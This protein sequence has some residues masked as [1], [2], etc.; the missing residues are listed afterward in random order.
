M[1]L[2]NGLAGSKTLNIRKT[3][4]SRTPL[5]GPRP[6]GAQTCRNPSLRST[7]PVRGPTPFARYVSPLS[8]NSSVADQDDKSQ[9]SLLYPNILDVSAT[10]PSPRLSA[11]N[12]SSARS[13]CVLCPHV[14][15]TTENRALE[16]GP[17]N[18]WVAVEVSGRL[19]QI[20]EEYPGEQAGVST[21]A[22]VDHELGTLHSFRLMYLLIILTDRFFEHGCL[23]DLTVDILPLNGSTITHV[24]RE[25]TFP[26]YVIRSKCFFVY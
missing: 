20:L 8:S 15:V 1:F 19:S 12:G 13:P 22:F 4:S 3:R 10:Q 24:L 16:A 26:A 2:G 9:S 17:Q 14:S 23:Y 11:G 7:L 25:Q 21:G 5:H 18:A 6:L